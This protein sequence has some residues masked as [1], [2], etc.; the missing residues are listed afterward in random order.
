MKTIIRLFMQ[1]FFVFTC[2][3]A[4]S[5]QQ[6]FQLILSQDAGF[7]TFDGKVTPDRGFVAAGIFTQ[8][9]GQELAIIKYDCEGNQEWMKTFGSTTTIQNVTTRCAVLQDST[10]AFVGNT[11]VFQAYNMVVARIAMDGTVLWSKVVN[12]G[13][14]NDGGGGVSGTDDNGVVVTG[15]TNSFGQETPG[16]SYRDVYLL[17]F[18]PDGNLEWSNIYGTFEAYDEGSV[19]IQT[20]DGGYAVGG[21]I[22]DRGAFHAFLMKTDPNG[23]PE[24]VRTYGDTLHS[25]WSFGLQ[26]LPDDG[27][28]LVGST[29]VMKTNFQDWTDNYIIRTDALGDTIWTRAFL[30]SNA[31][32]FENASSVEVDD[33]GNF[34][35][36][37][38]TASYP[39][40]GFVPNKHM[41]AKYQGDGTL[42]RAFLYNEGGSHYPRIAPSADGG[43]LLT[44]FS[45]YFTA[46]FCAWLSKTDTLLDP[47]CNL[48]DVTA[49]TASL[50]AP[51]V[52]RNV[53]LNE[54]TGANVNDYSLIAD[55][56]TTDTILCRQDP[57]DPV[58]VGEAQS[59]CV[60]DTLPFTSMSTGNLISQQWEFSDTT[61]MGDSIGRTFE[62]AGT[63]TALLRVSDGCKEDTMTVSFDVFE[64]P[65][66]SLGLDSTHCMGDTVVLDAG[67][68]FDGYVWSTGEIEQSIE[69]MEADAYSVT[70]SD[71]MCLGTDTIQIDFIDCDTVE[72]DLYKVPNA[73]T[74]D[75]DGVNDLWRPIL[76]IDYTLVSLDIYNRWGELVFTSSETN[77]FEWNGEFNGEQQPSDVYIYVMELTFLG[78][79]RVEK[80]DITLIR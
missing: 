28:V 41:I 31:D 48:Q 78:E 20:S 74:P 69:V 36:G 7:Q 23:T 38:A 55:V 66:V 13:L 19:V 70:V 8:N 16:G 4:F 71:G 44:G 27:F 9:G 3:H 68:G 21:R 53:S 73:F 17:K 6:T 77:T 32:R 11:G 12:Q 65:V 18:D 14:G 2:L 56:V 43:Y 47:G 35:I 51:F 80:G 64:L 52:V 49:L 46:D 15:Y 67:D 29:T 26:Q 76:G 42:E 10:I 63:Y 61:I 54:G 50:P 40:T 24:F 37:V 58:A 59:G 25:N 5:Q 22:I 75:G 30:G 33:E 62:V 60:G 34:Y 57:P 45:N 79:E 1:A 72:T 39:T